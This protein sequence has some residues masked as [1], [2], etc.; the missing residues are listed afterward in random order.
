MQAVNES[1]GH[2][3]PES[4]SQRCTDEPHSQDVEGD[5]CGK[6]AQA[7]HLL[8]EELG[9]QIYASTACKQRYTCLKE[10]RIIVSRALLPLK[11]MHRRGRPWG[12]FIAILPTSAS[13]KCI[14]L[15]SLIMCQLG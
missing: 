4:G 8:R 7:Q 1:E 14:A 13:S 2:V 15:G 6:V 5:G 9:H 12:Y 11:Y 10:H 3:G